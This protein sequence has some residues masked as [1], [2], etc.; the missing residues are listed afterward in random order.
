V[1]AAVFQAA[2]EDAEQ[3]RP[4]RN[5]GLFCVREGAMFF[6]LTLR[7]KM[8]YYVAMKKRAKGTKQMAY[9]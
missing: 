9:G 4:R 2:S 5:P 8:V 1:G 3:E 7:R 6:R